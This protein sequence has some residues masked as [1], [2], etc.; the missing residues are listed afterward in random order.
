MQATTDN[1]G[2]FSCFIYVE[3]LAI[4]ASCYDT[5]GEKKQKMTLLYVMTFQKGFSKLSK[6]PFLFIDPSGRIIYPPP[7]ELKVPDGVC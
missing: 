3:P 7:V 4:N 6:T 1:A 2:L 5:L